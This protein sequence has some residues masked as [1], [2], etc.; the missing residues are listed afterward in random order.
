MQTDVKIQRYFL[1]QSP[2]VLYPQHKSI[3]IMFPA[4]E[5]STVRF[6]FPFPEEQRPI[7]TYGAT[8]HLRKTW[9]LLL[10][11]H[12]PCLLQMPMGVL[13]HAP[14]ICQPQ[15]RSEPKRKAVGDQTLAEL[16]QEPIC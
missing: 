14:G 4:T 3:P 7:C 9:L 8:D 10:Q 13:P 12:I 6:R 11:E 1:L 16:I 5:D 2:M 15:D